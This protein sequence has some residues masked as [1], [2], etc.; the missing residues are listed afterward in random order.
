MLIGPGTALSRRQPVGPG[1][2]LGTTRH[3]KLLLVPCLGREPGTRHSTARH[4]VGIVPDSAVSDRVGLL[5]AR[6]GLVPYRPF[7]KL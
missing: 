7:G 6:A 2:A 1:R 5:S 3:E 4:E